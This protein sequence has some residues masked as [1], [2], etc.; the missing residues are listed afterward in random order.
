[1]R[2]WRIVPTE[3]AARFA[4]I[5]LPAAAGLSRVAWRRATWVQIFGAAGVSL[6]VGI[7]TYIETRQ[8]RGLTRP[9][10]PLCR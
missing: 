5:E 1:M 9:Q 3:E 8:K 6:A 4:P 7:P 2:D 10:F